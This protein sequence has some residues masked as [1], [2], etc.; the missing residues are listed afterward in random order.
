[1]AEVVKFF[2]DLAIGRSN[3]GFGKGGA[4]F[5]LCCFDLNLRVI[6]PQKNVD[7]VLSS[8]L[9]LSLTSVIEDGEALVSMRACVDTDVV[10]VRV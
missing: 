5:F 3:D 6:L 8:S 2:K 7:L 9:Q 1:M 4:R 10:E